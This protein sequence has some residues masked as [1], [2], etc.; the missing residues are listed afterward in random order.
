LYSSGWIYFF[1]SDV[2]VLGSRDIGFSPTADLV[3]TKD[4]RLIGF[5][6]L[7]LF[8]LSVDDAPLQGFWSVARGNARRT[9]RM[10]D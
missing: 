5:N 4:N 3:L 7:G 9:G 8:T 6:M 1:S 10:N 2:S